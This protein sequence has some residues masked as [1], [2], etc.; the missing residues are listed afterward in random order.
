MLPDFRPSDP[1]ATTLADMEEQVG[2]IHAT[3]EVFIEQVLARI[4][5]TPPNYEPIIRLNETGVLP[6]REATGLEAG[7]NCCA[8]F[9]R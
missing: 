3:R 9:W 5:S 7:A 6:E 8:I 4:L 2:V 1:V